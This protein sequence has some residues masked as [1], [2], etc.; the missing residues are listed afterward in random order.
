MYPASVTDGFSSG[1]RFNGVD[2]RD[3]IVET[4]HFNLLP[5]H[6]A[7]AN[8]YNELG[9]TAESTLDEHFPTREVCLAALRAVV[10]ANRS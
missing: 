6:M 2:S 9:R 8:F 7:L 3:T 10:V 1:Q 5:G 4:P